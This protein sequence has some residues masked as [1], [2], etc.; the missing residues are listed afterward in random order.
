MLNFFRGY[1]YCAHA[2]TYL[3]MMPNFYILL[4]K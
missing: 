4:N 3:L 1:F 2:L